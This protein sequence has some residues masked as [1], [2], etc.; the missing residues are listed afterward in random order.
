MIQSVAISGQNWPLSWLIDLRR[1]IP[2]EVISHINSRSFSLPLQNNVSSELCEF[3][4]GDPE[5]SILGKF[6]EMR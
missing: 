2:R 5:I 3:K 6:T 4:T 1:K